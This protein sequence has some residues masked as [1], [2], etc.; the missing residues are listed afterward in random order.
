MFRIRTVSTGVAG[1]PFYTN[2]YYDEASSGGAQ[3]C[4]DRVRLM[5]ATWTTIHRN[6]LVHTIDPDVALVDVTTG[7]ITDI[8][9]VSVLPV[10]CTRASDPLPSFTQGLIRLRTDGVVRGRRVQGRIFIPGFT[11]DQSVNGVPSG[12]N[13]TV[14]AAQLADGPRAIPVVWSRPLEVF[15][16]PVLGTQHTVTSTSASSSWSVLRS[17][18]S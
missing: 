5:W 16:V 14:A 18:R 10:A 3:A 4:A 9:T 17:R 8:D 1:A 7:D 2:I 13:L 15:G 11:E 12:T 6:G